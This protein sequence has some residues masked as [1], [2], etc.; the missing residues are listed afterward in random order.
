MGGVCPFAL[1]RPVRILLDTSLGK[2]DV[3]YAA[4]G[5]PHSALPIT[6]DQL[7]TITGGEIVDLT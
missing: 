1:A 4:A 7:A 3:V 5:T 2:Y 6:L